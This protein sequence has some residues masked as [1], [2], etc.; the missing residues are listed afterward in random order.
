MEVIDKITEVINKLFL[1]P[2]R[3]K[4]CKATDLFEDKLRT[5]LLL[6]VVVLLVVVVTRAGRA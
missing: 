3:E 5:S 1:P 2:A 4:T 6:S